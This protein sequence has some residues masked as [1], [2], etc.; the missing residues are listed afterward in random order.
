MKTSESLGICPVCKKGQIIQGRENYYCN[1]FVNINDKCDFK[2]WKSYYSKEITPE[3]VKEIIAKGS[4]SI[5]YDLKTK[6]NVLFSAYFSLIDGVL[7]PK[8]PR[9]YLS[10]RCPL[11]GGRILI[12]TSG[13][14]CANNF[15]VN[16]DLTAQKCNLFIPS[17]I[18]GAIIDDEMARQLLSGLYTA[19]FDFINPHT[20][21]FLSRLNL[22]N[23]KVVFDNFV[24]LCPKCGGNI[25]TGKKAYNCTNR[26]NPE[27][28]CDF[29]VWNEINGKYIH[30]EE[31]IDLCQNKSTIVLDGFYYKRSD[32]PY[33]GRLIINENFKIN[34]I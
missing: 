32:T 5:F 20:G 26:C 8:F 34:F 12:T 9:H 21:T 24:C 25:I 22:V 33:S 15:N 6:N 3:I 29:V 27:I 4:T 7:T 30:P 14:I 17:I 2:I 11:C 13:Y 16:T 18:S 19:F 10:A 1:H 23:G 31:V 28:N